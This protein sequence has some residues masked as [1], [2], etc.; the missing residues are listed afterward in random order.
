MDFEQDPQEIETGGNSR[1]LGDFDE[2]IPMNSAIK[3]AAA[4]P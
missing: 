3:K 4:L 2:G 1:C